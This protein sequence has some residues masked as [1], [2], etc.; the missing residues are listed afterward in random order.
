MI[1]LVKPPRLRKRYQRWYKGNKETL[2]NRLARHLDEPPPGKQKSR[3]WISKK[4]RE[5]LRGMLFPTSSH[6]CA[7][8]ESEDP[9]IDHFYPKGDENYRKLAFDIDNLVPCCDKCNK[10]KGTRVRDDRGNEMV[11]PYKVDAVRTHLRLRL[12]DLKLVGC[13]DAGRASIFLLRRRL[14]LLMDDKGH[15]NPVPKTRMQLKK[16][17]EETLSILCDKSLKWEPAQI[18]RLLEFQLKQIR[19]DEPYT[20]AKATLLLTHPQYHK[21]KQWLAKRAP[22]LYT[23]LQALEAEKSRYCLV[24]MNPS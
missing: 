9:Q 11:N 3:D 20:A 4:H 2:Q 16:T 21:L 15:K 13:S 17:Y 12:D 18:H 7:Y 24:D 8:C 14:N 6:K 1:P 22:E 10:E 19:E 5:E 23:S